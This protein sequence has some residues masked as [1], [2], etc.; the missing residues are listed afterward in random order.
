MIV[1][2]F[3]PW[4]TAL[5][6]VSVSGT[7]GDGWIVIG[8]AAFSVA[9]LW[10]FATRGSR[11]VLIGSG[12][13]GA[14]GVLIGAVDLADISSRGSSQFFGQQVQLIE[15]GWGIYLVIGASAALI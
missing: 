11:G 14:A 3:G 10:S 5:N 15:P 7:H 6:V 12:L 4:A 8:V 9:M 2:A 1:G 13:A